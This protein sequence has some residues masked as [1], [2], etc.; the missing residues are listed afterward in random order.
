MKTMNI[1]HVIFPVI[2]SFLTFG[3]T[4]CG[5]DDGDTT[6]P[7][8]NVIAP[9]E[10]ATLL[11][12]DE[13]GVLFKAEFSDDTA[14]KSYKLE[15]HNATNGHTHGA[16]KLQENPV[17]FT[18]NKSYELG[19]VRNAKVEHRDIVI[20]ENATPGHYHLMVYVT[21]VAGNQTYMARDIELSHDSS[22][23]EE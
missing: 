18:F 5:G 4:S 12:G 15:I 21:D 6:R 11:I 19:G 23:H 22:V 7:T 8:I 13:D 17:Y 9:E 10:D 3:T 2:L 16:P 14:L 20:P 1:K